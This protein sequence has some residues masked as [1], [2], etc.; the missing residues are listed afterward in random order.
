MRRQAIGAALALSLLASSCG[1][2]PDEAALRFLGFGETVPTGNLRNGEPTLANAAFMNSSQGAGQAAGSTGVVVYRAHIDYRTAGLSPPSSD[3]EFTLYLPPPGAGSTTTGILTSLPLAPASL[4]QWLVN[5]GAFRDA[6]AVPAAELTASIVFYGETDEG[7]A[8][9]TRVETKIVLA[10]NANIEPPP[11]VPKVPLPPTP[12]TPIS[13][14]CS[15]NCSAS[16][17]CSGHDGVN[18]SAGPDSD[19]S[20][21]CFDGWRDSTVTYHC[22]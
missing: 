4:K 17:A 13:S 11:P 22:N 9:E 8:L 5:T 12:E 16:G 2:P 14:T 18:C 15:A 10:N 20:V 19:G 7:G 21:I 6:A 3:H 1:P